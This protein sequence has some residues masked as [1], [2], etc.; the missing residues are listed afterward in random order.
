MSAV[1][2]L[3]VKIEEE[4]FTMQETEND[5]GAMRDCDRNYAPDKGNFFKINLIF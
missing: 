5:M 4:T 3:S 1:I 2:D